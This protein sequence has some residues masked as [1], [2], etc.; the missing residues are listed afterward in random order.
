MDRVSEG[1]QTLISELRVSGDVRAERALCFVAQ[2]CLRQGYAT[3]SF[4]RWHGTR[5]IEHGACGQERGA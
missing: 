1:G 3:K 5:G 2:I 4:R